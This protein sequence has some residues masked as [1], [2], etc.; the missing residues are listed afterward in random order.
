MT[1]SGKAQLPV[2]SLGTRFPAQEIL[3]RLHLIL[4]AAALE[5]GVAISAAFLG[6]HGVFGEDG[7]EHV[8][9]VDLGTVDG[10]LG[11]WIDFD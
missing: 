10:A 8:G 3:E 6:V 4:A 2:K 5:H 11:W 7:V 9:A 1:V